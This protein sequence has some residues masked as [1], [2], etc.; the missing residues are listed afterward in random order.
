MK[1]EEQVLCNNKEG[2]SEA[3]HRHDEEY[4]EQQAKE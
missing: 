2:K 1:E 4:L 3:E